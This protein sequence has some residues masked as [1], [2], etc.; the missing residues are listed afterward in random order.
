MSI[1]KKHSKYLKYKSLII[2]NIN[3][4]LLFIF[5]IISCT[6]CLK[7]RLLGEY[8]LTEEMKAQIPYKGN[9][10]IIF[11]SDSNNFIELVA[12]NRENEIAKRY[13]GNQESDY[14]LWEIDH[15]CLLNEYYNLSLWM[16]ADRYEPKGIAFDFEYLNGKYFFSGNFGLFLND[17]VTTV[18]DSIYINGTW[19][20]HIY[21]DTMTYYHDQPFPESLEQYPIKSYYSKTFGVVKIDFS[22][23]STWELKEIVW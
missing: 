12:G 7:D 3:L 10:T 14:E 13:I 21:Y 6:S 18:L 9:E 17:S 23:G 15:I 2:N 20:H 11:K 22:D 8:Y 19:F 1:L 4:F 16:N 5:L